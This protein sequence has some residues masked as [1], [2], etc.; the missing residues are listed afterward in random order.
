MKRIHHLSIKKIRIRRLNACQWFLRPA[1]H[2][3]A[4]LHLGFDPGHGIPGSLVV[5]DGNGAGTASGPLPGVTR[6]DGDTG[7]RIP[8]S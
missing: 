6:P 5:T 2:N 4:A 7:S 8:G 3:K 1:Q